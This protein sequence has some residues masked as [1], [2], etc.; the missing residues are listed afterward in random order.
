MATLSLY[1]AS[2]A[3]PR[4]VLARRM[5]IV[6]RKRED[7]GRL[8]LCNHRKERRIL[9]AVLLFVLHE[10]LICSYILIG[11]RDCCIGL[12]AASVF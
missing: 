12:G 4:F 8:L 6:V 1:F 3:A 5:R 7:L 10:Q 11:R 2:I 9:P